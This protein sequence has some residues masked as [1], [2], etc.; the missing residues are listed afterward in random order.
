MDKTRRVEP[1]YYSWMDSCGVQTMEEDR[2]GGI[3]SRAVSPKIVSLVTGHHVA[4]NSTGM[5][6][7]SEIIDMKLSSDHSGA[8]D[9]AASGLDETEPLLSVTQRINKKREGEWRCRL[10]TRRLITDF[11]LA[12]DVYMCVLSLVPLHYHNALCWW[13]VCTGTSR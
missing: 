7:P 3:V 12:S 11:F 8:L 6:N 4:A 13:Q 5:G 10:D 2:A 1:A 9:G